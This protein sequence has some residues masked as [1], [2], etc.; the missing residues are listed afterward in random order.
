M[1]SGVV[2]R[3]ARG[4]RE[5]LIAKIPTPPYKGRWTFPSGPIEEGE[6]PEAAVRRALISTL[7]LRVRIVTG[8]PPFDH[9]W[10][11]VTC[12]WRFFFCDATGNEVHNVYFSEVRWIPRGALREYDFDPVSQ[13]VVDWLLEESR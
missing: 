1:A 7:G 10:D 8:Q 9:A 6:A 5:V 3:T 13:Q 11:E 12:R 4:A 2:E